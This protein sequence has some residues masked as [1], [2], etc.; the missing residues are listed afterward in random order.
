[1]LYKESPLNIIID[2]GFV[3]TAAA[4]PFFLNESTEVCSIDGNFIFATIKTLP[5]RCFDLDN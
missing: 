2:S 1:M 3:E 5:K 4:L